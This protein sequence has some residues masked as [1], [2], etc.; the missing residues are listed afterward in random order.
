MSTQ[1]QFDTRAQELGAK[2]KEINESDKTVTEKSAAL[3]DLEK[4]ITALREE[5]NAFTKAAELA[6]QLGDS[7]SAKPEAEEEPVYQVPN[8]KQS[9]AAIAAN[10]MKHPIMKSV[11]KDAKAGTYTGERTFEVGAKDATAANNLIGEGLY[12]T[13]G[14]TAAGQNPF[15]PGAFGP[16]ILPQFIPG[17]VEQRFYPLTV[18]DLIPS[19]AADSPNLTYLVE[20]TA[21]MNANQTAE[22]ALYPFSSE[23]F[24]RVYEQVGKI[25]NAGV[26]TDET[27]H[28]APSL[29][30]F[31]LNRL[32]EGIQRKEE[33]QLLAGGGY[34]GVNGLLSRSTGFTKPQTITAVTNVKIPANGTAGVGALQETVASLTYGRKIAGTGTTGTAPTA[35]QIAEGIYSAFVDIQLGVMYSPNYVLMHPLDWETVR[36]GKD[37]QQQY[38]GGNFFGNAYGNPV[39]G[40]ESLWGVPVVKTVALPQGTVLVGYFDAA[41]LQAARRQGVTFQTTNSNVDDF[42]NGRVT[43]RAEERL[44]L[45]VY[46]PAAF[47]LIQLVPAP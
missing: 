30:Q 36:L 13:T 43:V 32:L 2:L 21:V 24:S 25:T 34:P 1:A 9:R 5:R 23:T 19:I 14:P 46:R 35:L 45:M 8:L 28:D 44:G 40:S 29:Y 42:V 31:F 18:A 27:I 22:N 12:G 26:L 37:Q 10:L 16:G 4:D 47:E 3:A 6:K 17:I 33:L 11:L 7:G 41:T 15:L 38:Y 20:A 39:P